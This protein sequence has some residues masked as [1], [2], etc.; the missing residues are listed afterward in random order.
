MKQLVPLL[1]LASL[2]AMA[3]FKFGVKAGV[4]ASSAIY[5]P[6]GAI[7]NHGITAWQT[8]A[9]AQFG[10]GK[11]IL[12]KA[13]LLLNQKG[14]YADNAEHA[15]D[16]YQKLTYRLTYLEA[17]LAIA[18]KIKMSRHFSFN[19][20]AGP[21]LGRG[22]Y[23]REKGYE[24]NF[25]AIGSINRKVIFSDS[26]KPTVSQSTFKQYDYGLNVNATVQYRKY[27]L[28]ANFQRGLS[29][30]VISDLAG[31]NSQN[32]VFTAGLGYYFK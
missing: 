11:S 27:F 13:G 29:D 30:R 10:L 5:R 24:Y 9:F 15:V 32:Q 2:P 25:G 8:G 26:Q 16:Y 21:Y 31:W 7:N 17:D 28:Y 23:G 20:G 14:N 18:F 12:L 1:L 3:Q 6:K 19:I 4:N 22:I